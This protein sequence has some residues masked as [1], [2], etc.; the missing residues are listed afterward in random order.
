VSGR[1]G[2]QGRARGRGGEPR[3]RVVGGLHPV[4]ELL[5][6]GR[7][8]DRILVAAGRDDVPVLADIRDLA[9]GA[10]IRVEPVDRADL[11]ALTD[12]LVH[13]GVVALAPPF[14][15]VPLED[16]LARADAAGEAALLVALDGVTD[17]HNLGS[18]ARTAEAVGAHGLLV[19]GRRS[20]GI[21]PT[22]EKAAAGAL[23]HLPVVVVTNLVRTLGQLHERGVWSLGLDGSAS[24]ELAAHPLA[25]EPCVLVVGAE[26]SGLARLT[27]ERCDALVRLPMRGHVA[28]LNASVAAGIALYELVRQRG[29]TPEDRR[30]HRSPSTAARPPREG[31]P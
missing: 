20:A 3:E 12:G 14:A 28:S 18:I 6:A 8:V 15:P 22:G 30:A 19:P 13:Q 31:R 29:G 11:D 10:G 27:R 16:V 5:R 26:G 7:P 2:R 24:D 17:P 21:T 9:A 4:R 25:S 1:G 23:A